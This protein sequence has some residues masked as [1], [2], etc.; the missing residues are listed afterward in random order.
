MIFASGG[1][2][3]LIKIWKIIYNPKFARFS[4]NEI[5]N[6][7]EHEGNIVKIIKLDK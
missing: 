7:S 6:L 5:K 4:I 3:K 1:S 2:D